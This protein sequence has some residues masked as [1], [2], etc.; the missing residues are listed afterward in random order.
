MYNALRQAIKALSA[1]KGRTLLTT[2]GIMIG[3]A[4]V[5][6]VLS[7]GAGF[8]LLISDQ[9]ETFGTNTLYVN[10][11]VPSKSKSMPHNDTGSGSK[12]FRQYQ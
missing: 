8:R 9:I 5:I 3:I 11:K 12:G 1:N 7:A 4:T 6:L 2:L 10:T